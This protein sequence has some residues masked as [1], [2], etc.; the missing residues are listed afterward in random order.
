[1]QGVFPLK[2]REDSPVKEALNL[3][4]RE[5]DKQFEDEKKV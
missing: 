1:M 2:I 3:L 4:H 5:K